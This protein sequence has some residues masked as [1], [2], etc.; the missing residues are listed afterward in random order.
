MARWYGGLPPHPAMIS[1]LQK[2]ATRIIFH[3]DFNT[4][5]AEMLEELC[6][7][8]ILKRLKYNTAIF[9]YKAMGLT[10]QYITEA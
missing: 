9:T 3:A 6:W 1:K 4:P 2:R 7:L 8:P 5:S 10:P